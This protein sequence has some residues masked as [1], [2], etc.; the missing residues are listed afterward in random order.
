MSNRFTAIA[1]Y[2]ETQGIA[3]VGTNLFI[4]T[5]PP[6]P[7]TCLIIT[8]YPGVAKSENILHPYD[9]FSFQLMSRSSNTET[10]FDLVM[11]AYDVLQGL[12]G[13]INGFWFVELVA[14]Q[15]S[16]LSMGKDALNRSLFSLN[17]RG[18]VENKT[19][20]RGN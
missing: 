16:P 1:E 11:A 3:T 5:L 18:E 12:G 9:T 2:L 13:L 14:L 15:Q 10:A 20:N 19:Q 8:P 6:E 7:D 17:F 4:N